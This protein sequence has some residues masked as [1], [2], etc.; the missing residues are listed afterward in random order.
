M[1]SH[2]LFK[3]FWLPILKPSLGGGTRDGGDD[4]EEGQPVM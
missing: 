4:V 1:S 2:R 3:D